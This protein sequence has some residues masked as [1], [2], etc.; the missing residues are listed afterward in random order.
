[1]LFTAI[2][3]MRIYNHLNSAR[4]YDTGKFEEVTIINCYQVLQ[5]VMPVRWSVCF[6]SNFKQTSL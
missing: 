1:M 6:H 3:F 5:S 4:I 2:L